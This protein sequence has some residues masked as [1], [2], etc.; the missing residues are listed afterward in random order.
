[1]AGGGGSS[2]GEVRRRGVYRREVRRHG[3]GAAVV[4]VAG[5]RSSPETA[6]GGGVAAGRGE[7]A[8]AVAVDS[9]AA[10]RGVWASGAPPGPPG[11]A[12]DGEVGRLRGQPAGDTWRRRG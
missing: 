2:R 9:R 3:L 11:P 5:R 10:G 8:S 12:A 4:E 7:D 1:M 6:P